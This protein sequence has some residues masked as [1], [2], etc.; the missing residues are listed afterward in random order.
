MHNRVTGNVKTIEA[1]SFEDPTA[2]TNTIFASCAGHY[3]LRRRETSPLQAFMNT[4]NDKMTAMA[5]AGG[6]KCLLS[7]DRLN[8]HMPSGRGYDQA[9]KSSRPGGGCST[10]SSKPN[11]DK[12]THVGE[13]AR[14][15]RPQRTECTCSCLSYQTRS[16]T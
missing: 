4:R 9:D 1:A 3:Q 16:P 6:Q 10:S 8:Y 7:I 5:Q 2:K 12:T 13:G 11:T 14:G 15:G